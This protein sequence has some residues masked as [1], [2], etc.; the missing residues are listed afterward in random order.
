MA[1][2]RRLT[3]GAA[4]LAAAALATLAFAAGCGGDSQPE[5]PRRA[6]SPAQA[7]STPLPATPTPSPVPVASG[8]PAGF[9]DDFPLYPAMTHEG[10]TDGSDND[11]DGLIYDWLS[12]DAVED[13]RN[14]YRA[15]FDGNP[16]RLDAGPSTFA[17][18][19]SFT[20]YHR[21]TPGLMAVMT[22]RP[23]P[24]GGTSIIVFVGVER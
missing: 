10:T 21:D 1:A 16:W 3:V 19:T 20:A 24:T 5:P 7:T 23:T 12:A 11:F 4:L 14:F 18:A 8:L 2:S 17:S 6:A 22:L 15:R 13:V 9:P